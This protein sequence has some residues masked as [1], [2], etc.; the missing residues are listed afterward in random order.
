MNNED[1]DTL[2]AKDEEFWLGIM[3]GDEDPD[4]FSLKMI[5]S[6]EEAGHKGMTYKWEVYRHDPSGRLVSLSSMWHYYDGL[7]DDY[8]EFSEVEQHTVMVEKKEY[9]TV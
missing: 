7:R 3:C 8:F 5:D 6:G 9:R 2:L 4:E 1:F